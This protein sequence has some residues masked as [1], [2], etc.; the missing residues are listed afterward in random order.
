VRDEELDQLVGALVEKYGPKTDKFGFGSF[1]AYQQKMRAAF[2]GTG[3][4]VPTFG[5]EGRDYACRM[6]FILGVMWLKGPTWH[7]YEMFQREWNKHVS[8]NLRI[9]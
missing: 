2:F 9:A 6:F 5:F 7:G 3:D 8:S 4:N 1:T